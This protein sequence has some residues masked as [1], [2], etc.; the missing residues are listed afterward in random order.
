MGREREFWVY[1]LELTHEAGP[2]INPDLPNV[3]VGETGRGVQQRLRVQI[4][5]GMKS[6]KTVRGKIVGLRPDLADGVGPFATRQEAVAAQ[7]ELMRELS[8]VGYTVRSKPG[9]FEIKPR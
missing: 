9:P 5:G 2:R 7:D 3:Y 1:V 4:A 8:K 6:A